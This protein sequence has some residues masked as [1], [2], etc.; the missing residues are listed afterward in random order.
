MALGLV[1]LGAYVYGT[2]RANVADPQAITP[3][4]KRPYNPDQGDLI[5]ARLNDLKLERQQ[6]QGREM[7]LDAGPNQPE[8]PDQST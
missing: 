4:P 5:I 3:S 8:T 7:E 1:L 6:L 2:A